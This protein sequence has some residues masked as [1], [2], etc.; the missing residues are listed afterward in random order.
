MAQT[1]E[2]IDASQN[3]ICQFTSEH[4]MRLRRFGSATPLERGRYL[5]IMNIEG[6][7]VY[8]TFTI[9]SSILPGIDIR[10]DVT[11]RLQSPLM[12]LFRKLVFV[13]C[14]NA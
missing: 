4:G 3:S 13:S 2:E 12:R 9:R 6:L 11:C 8:T 1:W 5:V 14:S 7:S 10:Y